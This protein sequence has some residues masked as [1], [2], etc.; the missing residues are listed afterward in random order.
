MGRNCRTVPYL[1]Y[2]RSDRT[3]VLVRLGTK[4][5]S[6]HDRTMRLDATRVFEGQCMEFA[7]LIQSPMGLRSNI[8][9]EGGYEQMMLIRSCLRS[10]LHGVSCSYMHVLHI[11]MC[12]K[13]LEGAKPMYLSLCWVKNVCKVV[14]HRSVFSETA[15]EFPKDCIHR[16]VPYICIDCIT[17]SGNHATKGIHLER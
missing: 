3:F 12:C 1:Y 11:C 15:F 6:V 14:F 4:L 17:V 16:T 10:P 8:L 9:K 7:F 5:I 13:V 2:R